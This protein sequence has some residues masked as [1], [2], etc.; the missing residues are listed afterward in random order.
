MDFY[1]LV[2]G[3]LAM[4]SFA[5]LAIGSC[6]RIMRFYFKGTNPKILYPEITIPNGRRA[7]LKGLTPFGTRFMRDRPIFTVVTILFHLCLAL[8]ALLFTA[9]N[10]LWFESWGMSLFSVSNRAA[11]IMTTV[12]MLSCIFFFARRLMVKEVTMVTQLSDFILLMVIFLTFLSGFMAFHQLGPY[13]N[14]LILHI[15]SCEIL[16]AMIPFT[17]LWHMIVYPFSRFYMGSDFGA[18]LNKQDW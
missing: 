5:I 8:V 16:I 7:I 2:R 12:V 18:V 6:F 9:H 14:L 13:R 3:P 4:L 15:L 10:V 1:E 17:R 11:D